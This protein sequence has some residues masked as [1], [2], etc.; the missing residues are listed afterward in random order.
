MQLLGAKNL[1]TGKTEKLYKQ[2]LQAEKD[3]TNE[4]YSDYRDIRIK[5]ING[6]KHEN[7]SV[8]RADMISRAQTLLG[9]VLFIAFAEDRELLP[10]RTLQ[11]YIFL[12]VDNSPLRLM[13]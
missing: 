3:I 6:M 10:Q 4:L 7:N 5:M 13:G 9:R 8:R 1:I 12:S 11:E 2:S